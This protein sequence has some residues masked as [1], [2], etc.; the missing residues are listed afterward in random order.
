V[1]SVIATA[2]SFTNC[3]LQS[4]ASTS[5]VWICPFLASVKPT[6]E[7]LHTNVARGEGQGLLRRKILAQLTERSAHLKLAGGKLDKV[8][9]ELLG[10]L[11]VLPPRGFPRGS[12][13]QI[14]PG[15]G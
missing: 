1:H 5:A 2:A 15:N 7:L 9:A 13:T 3:F 14:R 4:V 6:N 12:R 11:A 8:F 10:N